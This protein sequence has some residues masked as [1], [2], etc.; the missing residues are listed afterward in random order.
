MVKA[1]MT[2]WRLEHHSRRWVHHRACHRTGD[3]R[4]AQFDSARDF[5]A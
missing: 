2:M 4:Q 5:A 3:R 1:D